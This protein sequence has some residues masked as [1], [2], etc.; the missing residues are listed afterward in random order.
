MDWTIVQLRGFQSLWKRERLADED[1][2]RLEELIMRD[3]AAAPVMRGTGGLRK[4]RFAPPS[5]SQGKSGAT[6]V[7][8][9]QFP[10]HGRIY[11]VTMLLKKSEDN[12]SQADRNSIRLA[13]ERIKL[14]LDQ[15]E[16]P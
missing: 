14:A 12:F 15:G 10:E 3:P 7:A 8:Y 1:L 9:A 13:L 6:R 2:Q 5:R 16:N 4:I 11:L